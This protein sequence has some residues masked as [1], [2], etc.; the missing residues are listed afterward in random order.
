MNALLVIDMQNGCFQTPRYEKERIVSNINSLIEYFRITNQPIYFIQHNG[1]KENYMFP[2]TEDYQII[3]ELHKDI[4]DNF[5]EKTVNN[6]F[7]ETKLE[8]KLV[9]D[10]VRTIYITGLATEFCVNAT[11]LDALNR[12][13]NIVVVNDSHTTANRELMNANKIIEFYNW[14][15][16]NL[17][18][19]KGSIMSKSVKEI[20]DIKKEKE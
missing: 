9:K 14:L 1:F 4:S 5:I 7:Y 16:I 2:E 13:F 17:T 8:E 12:N 6:A 11:I 20:I 19:T 3:K 10:K 18:P 15:W